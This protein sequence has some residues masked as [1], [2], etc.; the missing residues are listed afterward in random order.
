MSQC[1]ANQADAERTTHQAVGAVAADQVVGLNTLTAA[2]SEIDDVGTDAVLPDFKGFQPCQIVEV[3]VGERAGKALQYRVK[4]HLRANLEAHR[5]VRLGLL[6]HA[7]WP[8]HTREL[9]ARQR[10]HERDIK[11]VIARK[12][13]GK[14]ILRYAPT[15]AELHCPDVHFV[16]FRR[17]N[18]AVALL[19]QRTRHAAPAELARE[20]ESNWSA[21][22][23]QYRGPPHARSLVNLDVGDLAQGTAFLE[24][25]GDG[26][27]KLLGRPWG[28]DGA[29][30]QDRLLHF[31]RSQRLVQRSV[32][33]TDDY[34]GG[35]HWSHKAEKGRYLV[36]GNSSLDH[37]RQVGRER[38]SCF[39]GHRERAQFSFAD[40][41][42][43]DG[44]ILERHVDGLAEYGSHRFAA[45]AVGNADEVHTGAGHEQFSRKMCQVAR[46]DMR[47]IESARVGL[48]KCNELLNRLPRRGG[49]HHQDLEAIHELRDRSEVLRGIVARAARHRGQDRKLGA[50]SRQ[51]RVSV[52]HGL[53]GFASA[54]RATGAGTILHHNRL[55]ELWSQNL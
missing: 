49:A 4:P 46:A 18:R 29:D 53:G 1:P 36:V 22:D 55:P 28:G 12:R 15:P 32:E 27:R 31:R 41:G 51:Q 19:D 38:R 48:S 34:A 54:E 5:A 21:T 2:T 43:E 52:W 42:Q 7:R 30:L 35:A 45:A 8:R 39:A 37:R 50:A 3:D 40:E 47:V 11:R 14:D 25:G 20:G 24:I 16:H 6:A 17:D 44:D 23:N 13:A 33:L 26:R 10:R 9:V